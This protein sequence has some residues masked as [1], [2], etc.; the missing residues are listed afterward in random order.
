MYTPAQ[1]S[2]DA[3]LLEKFMPSEQRRDCWQVIYLQIWLKKSSNL[4]IGRACKRFLNF[5]GGLPT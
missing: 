5:D 1:S 3:T 2:S 4:Y